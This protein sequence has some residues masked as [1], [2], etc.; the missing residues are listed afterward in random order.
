MKRTIDSVIAQKQCPRVWRFRKRVPDFKL[1]YV[2]PSATIFSPWTK[3]LGFL[4]AVFLS[5][6]LAFSF[7]TNAAFS[8]NDQ[9]RSNNIGTGEWMPDIHIEEKRNCIR[10]S[11]SLT[12]ANI[13]YKFSDDGDPRTK[14]SLFDGKCIKIPEG[15]QVDFEARAFHPD[16][17]T[18]RSDVL[19]KTF[20][21]ISE[22]KKSREESEKEGGDKEKDKE[23]NESHDSGDSLEKAGD[24]GE[25]SP[26]EVCDDE[27][28]SGE[29]SLSDEKTP[30]SSHDT[31]SHLD[32][33]TQE[34][35]SQEHFSKEDSSVKDNDAN[36]AKSP[37][38]QSPPSHSDEHTVLESH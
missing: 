9:L 1:V 13:Y 19:R 35:K 12:S 38:A 25:S 15:K 6:A 27:S 34:G 36:S 20:S 3:R 17:D 37:S 29:I 10:L 21:H 8:D 7:S 18:W 2:A 11:S 26:G 24:Q 30:L 33:D 31:A 22:K 14:G 23:H 32:D 5:P 28:A 16:N 4:V